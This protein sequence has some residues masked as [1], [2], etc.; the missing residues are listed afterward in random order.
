MFSSARWVTGHIIAFSL[1]V[2]LGQAVAGQTLP[3]GYVELYTGLR[4]ATADPS[5]GIAVR[6]LTIRYDAATLRLDEGQLHQLT[7]IGGR[8]YGAVFVGQG[9]FSFGTP[10][11]VEAQQIERI[12][13]TDSLDVPIKTAVLFFSS[14]LIPELLGDIEWQPG[15]PPS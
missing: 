9:R 12:F 5:R 1:P 13:E 11:A 3:A 7:P 10:I 8:T 4:E 6:N 15:Q 14:E 2:M